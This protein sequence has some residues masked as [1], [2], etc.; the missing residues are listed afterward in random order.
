[1]DAATEEP[2]FD[3]T[4][5]TTQVQLQLAGNDGDFW[6]YPLQLCMGDCDKDAVSHSLYVSIAT[7]DL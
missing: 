7:E 2:S 4:E 6:V 3:P 5:E 1:M